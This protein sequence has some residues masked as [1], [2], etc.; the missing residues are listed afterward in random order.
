MARFAEYATHS[1]EDPAVI[2]CATSIV[3]VHTVL[4]LSAKVSVGVL[5]LQL[6]AFF[7]YLSLWR[8][9]RLRT[10]PMTWAIWV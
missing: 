9:L 3:T 8:H 4:S 10:P 7:E 2:F 6:L 1:L 5:G